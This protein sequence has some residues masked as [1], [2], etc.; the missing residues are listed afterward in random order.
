MPAYEARA[1]MLE[2]LAGQKTCLNHGKY[3]S[4]RRKSPVIWARKRDWATNL[5]RDKLQGLTVRLELV[6]GSLMVRQAH[7]EQLNLT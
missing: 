1:S 2:P 6:E 7:H 4:M 3:V 5:S